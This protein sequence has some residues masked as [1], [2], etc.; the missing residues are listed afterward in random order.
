[1]TAR[2]GLV[3]PAL[4]LIIPRS[5]STT[6]LADRRTDPEKEATMLVQD[7]I[8]Q[9]QAQQA[10]KRYHSRYDN[11]AFIRATQ[12][13]TSMYANALIDE[14]MAICGHPY[15]RLSHRHWSGEA[16]EFLEKFGG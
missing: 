3:L 16:Q 14:A 2:W 13:K 15:Y 4:V 11:H 9:C 8:A 6:Q 7:D 12:G 10:M 5:T 1:M